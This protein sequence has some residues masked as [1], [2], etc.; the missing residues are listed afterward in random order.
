MRKNCNKVRSIHNWTETRQRFLLCLKFQFS[1]FPLPNFPLVPLA[2]SKENRMLL[3][4]LLSGLPLTSGYTFWK[5]K[6]QIRFS[7]QTHCRDHHQREARTGKYRFLFIMHITQDASNRQCHKTTEE[8]FL[9]W[10]PKNTFPYVPFNHYFCGSR[11]KHLLNSGGHT[12]CLLLSA[13]I[14][15][16]GVFQLV[17]LLLSLC[18]STS[19]APAGFYRAS[20]LPILTG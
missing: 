13:V 7:Q 12:L 6:C 9:K 5:A 2:M 8:N 3:L 15:C 10:E 17:H 19:W 18:A 14:D 11:Y 4:L 1:S 20:Q 16:V